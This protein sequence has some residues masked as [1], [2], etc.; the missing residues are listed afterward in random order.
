MAKD[1]R[2]DLSVE[3]GAS[4]SSTMVVPPV[5]NEPSEFERFEQLAGKLVKVPKSELDEKLKKP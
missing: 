5:A 4:A 2:Y 3:Y 1:E